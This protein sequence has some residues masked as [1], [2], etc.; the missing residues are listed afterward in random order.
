MQET[1]RLAYVVVRMQRARLSG[2][3]SRGPH[4]LAYLRTTDH[5]SMSSTPSPPE[6]LLLVAALNHAES[7]RELT[8]RSG[9]TVLD[10]GGVLLFAPPHPTPELSNGVIRTGRVSAAE[11]LSRARAFFGRRKRG[12][13]VYTR[14]HADDDLRTACEAAHLH[15]MGD[16]PGMFVANRWPA[17]RPS[18]RDVTID[19]VRSSEDASDYARVMADA[20]SCTGMPADA[21]PALLPS[22]N[23]LRAPNIASVLIRLEGRPVAG[24]MVIVSH[25]VG[26]IYWVG[27]TPDARGRGLGPL[28]TRAAVKL[29]FDRGALVATLQASPM[30]DPVYRRMG[31]TEFMRYPLYVQRPLGG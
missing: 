24:A 21:A 26:G 3:I 9:G 29:G 5:R 14:A 27:T 11:V 12:Y 1:Y 31:F 7:Q 10:E 19:E 20:F 8:R 25:R 18:A 4:A 2:L 13:T 17:D 23:V 22:L 30:G 6:D 16:F 28:A 15:Y